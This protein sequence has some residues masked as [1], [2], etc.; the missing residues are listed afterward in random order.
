VRLRFE[1]RENLGL[2][3]PL[4]ANCVLAFWHRHLFLMVYGTPHPPLAVW[5]SQS[6]AGELI[7]RAVSHFGVCAARGSNSRGGLAALQAMA[8]MGRQGYSLCIAPDG[9]RG[10]A[11]EVKPG[12]LMVAVLAGL[13]ILPVAYAAG[14]SWRAPGWDGMVVPQ[15]FTT[16]QFVYGEPLTVERGD[17]LEL[18]GAELK[19]RLDGAEQRAVALLGGAAPSA[20]CGA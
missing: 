8:R 7:T 3:C 6:D 14:R 13:P 9:P 18:A 19:R 1:A 2:A 20:T 16:V 15:P 12:A 10:P 11:G 5:T 17:D 4:G